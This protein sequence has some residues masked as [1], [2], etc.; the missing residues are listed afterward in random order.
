MYRNVLATHMEARRDHQDHS[1]VDPCFIPLELGFSFSLQLPPPVVL[2]LQVRVGPGLIFRWMLEIQTQASMC[3]YVAT[4][5]RL[6]AISL[7]C[8][9]GLLGIQHGDSLQ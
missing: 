1:T 8:H 4:A 7:P 5:L 2:R 9:K 6:R 3:M